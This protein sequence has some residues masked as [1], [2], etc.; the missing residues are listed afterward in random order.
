[1]EEWPEVHPSN[2]LLTRSQDRTLPLVDESLLLARLPVVHIQ[3][4]NV[5]TVVGRVIGA[6]F[7]KKPGVVPHYRA[8]IRIPH[9]LERGF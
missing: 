3:P 8:D 5:A 7:L 2:R 9:I 6:G 4:H 1:M